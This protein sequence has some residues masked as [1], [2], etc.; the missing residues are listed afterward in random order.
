MRAC[1]GCSFYACPC[2]CILEFGIS[3]LIG[4]NRQFGIKLACQ[5]GY[6]RGIA[7]RR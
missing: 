1:A 7:V 6:G 2:Q 3:S 5:L 4:N